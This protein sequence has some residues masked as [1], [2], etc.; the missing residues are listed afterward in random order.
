MET[1]SMRKLLNYDI[2]TEINFQFQRKRDEFLDA[3]NHNKA[4]VSFCKLYLSVSV[5]IQLNHC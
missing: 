4:T 5:L 3:I 2:P 1:V